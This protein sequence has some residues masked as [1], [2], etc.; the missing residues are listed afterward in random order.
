MEGSESGPEE[1]DGEEEEPSSREGVG[2]SV[3]EGWVVSLMGNG[4]LTRGSVVIGILMEGE[5]LAR[6]AILFRVLCEE[7]LLSEVLVLGGTRGGGRR[8]E[9]LTEGGFGEWW[10][11][12]STIRSG[13]GW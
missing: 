10:R 1:E 11:S 12:K 3:V 13:E 8:R 5:P 4:E 6:V 7:D 9:E 2:S